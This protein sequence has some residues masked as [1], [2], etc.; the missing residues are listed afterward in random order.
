MPK[1]SFC[2][3]WLRSPV[4]DLILQPLPYVLFINQLSLG[5]LASKSF[6]SL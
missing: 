5:F 1:S 4:P 6:S 3:S 2:L